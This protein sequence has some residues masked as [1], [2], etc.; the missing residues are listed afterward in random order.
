M[1][2]LKYNLSKIPQLL[3]LNKEFIWNLE[4]GN[5]QTNKQTNKKH[6]EYPI[7]ISKLM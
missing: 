2:W 5:K 4:I 3:F 7:S 6:Q 1:I